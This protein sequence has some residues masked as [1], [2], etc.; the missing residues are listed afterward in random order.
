MTAFDRQRVIRDL[1]A[2]AQ[3]YQLEGDDLD[4]IGACVRELEANGEN[5]PA[6]HPELPRLTVSGQIRMGFA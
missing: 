4:A 2:M 5:Q 1:Q 3:E 6:D